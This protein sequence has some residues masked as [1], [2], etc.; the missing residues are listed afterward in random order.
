MTVRDDLVLSWALYDLGTVDPRVLIRWAQR[1]C[2][3][4]E[5]DEHDAV[6]VRL[7]M[8]S[9]QTPRDV[10]EGAFTEAVAALG[11]EFPDDEE[12]WRAFAGSIANAMLTDQI[13]P[14]DATKV[15]AR[16]AKERE[17]LSNW[18]HIEACFVLVP[19][20]QFAQADVDEEAHLEAI[21]LLEL[22][23]APAN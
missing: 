18:Q 7:A 12:T 11:E 19:S 15:L 5:G 22:L 21:A 3:A 16:L 4:E 17:E 20:G 2:E 1:F 10:V 14:R 23:S 6:V 9:P 13:T 8:M